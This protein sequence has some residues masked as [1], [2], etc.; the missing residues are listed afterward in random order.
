MKKIIVSLFVL[1]LAGGIVFAGGGKAAPATKKVLELWHIQTTDPF[2]A[3]IQ[4]SVDRFVAANPD[5]QVNISPIANDSYKDKIAIAMQSQKLPDVFFSWSGGPM[6]GY[7]DVGVIVDLTPYMNA[8][9]HKAKY[10]DAALAQ[11]TYKGKV[12]GVPVENVAIAMVFY[13]KA[14]YAKYGLSVP[15]TLAQLEANADVLLKNGIK[16]FSLAN[17]APWTGDMYYQFFATRYGGTAPFQAALRGQGS[18]EAQNFVDAAAKIQEW[19]QKGYFNEGINSLAEDSGQSR[20]LLY[21]GQA[22]M[23]VM[24]SWAVSQIQS[25]NPDYYK[26]LGL[27]NFPGID[28]AVG[29][30]NTVLGTVGDNFYHVAAS[31]KNPDKAFELITYLLDDTAVKARIA[32]GRIPPI[33]G[34]TLPDAI[35]QQLVEALGKAPDLQ[36]W[37][38]QSLT[39]AV[40]QI[41]LQTA[42]EIWGLSK[43]PAQAAKEWAAAQ[44]ENQ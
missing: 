1:L 31:S 7:A 24:G 19:V 33:K 20:A 41:H 37:Y 40:T 22:G 39:P 29:N 38:D 11:A 26:D 27:F 3:I 6:E 36:F 34:V 21:N 43:T 17:Q 44:K 28:G 2:P 10:L 32:G 18:F 16:P 4:G 13:N 42:Q 12:W 14:M 9:N 15:T 30:P 5:Y 8:N 23:Y 25:E 35:S